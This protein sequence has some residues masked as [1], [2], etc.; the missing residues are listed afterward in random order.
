MNH[1]NK[2]EEV[3]VGIHEFPAQ[4]QSFLRISAR[5]LGLADVPPELLHRHALPTYKEVGS[6]CK[7]AIN[8]KVTQRGAA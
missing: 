4:L 8:H 5:Y 6:G 2:Y 3:A 7:S 1:L